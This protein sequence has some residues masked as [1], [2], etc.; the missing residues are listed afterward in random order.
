MTS[1]TPNKPL[2]FNYGEIGLDLINKLER[3]ISLEIF[4]KLQPTVLGKSSRV[5]KQWRK[6]AMDE[7]LQN[8]A[9]A[10]GQKQWAEL[11]IYVEEP[12]LPKDIKSI[13]K[14][15]CLFSKEGKKG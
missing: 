9:I 2:S 1:I 13:L 8:P 15:P 3:D 12:S 14:S 10:F 5:C 4:S 6:L 7:S 11:G